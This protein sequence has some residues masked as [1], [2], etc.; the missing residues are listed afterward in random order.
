MKQIQAPGT[1]PALAGKGAF[2]TGG[3]PKDEVDFQGGHTPDLRAVRL[4][5]LC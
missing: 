5:I 1:T 3:H 2:A 4:L